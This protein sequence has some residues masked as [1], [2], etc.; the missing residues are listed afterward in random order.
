[1]FGAL[2]AGL[3]LV[4]V[5]IFADQF[6]NGRRIA[7]AGASVTVEARPTPEGIRRSIDDSDA[8]GIADSITKVLSE[9]TF[10]DRANEIVREISASS[11]SGEM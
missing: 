11:C 5:P 2:G 4:V 6:E 10:R 1:M 7:A 8:P 3:P 9:R